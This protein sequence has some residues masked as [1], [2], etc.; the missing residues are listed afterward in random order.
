MVSNPSAQFEE[1]GCLTFSRIDGREMVWHIIDACDTHLPGHLAP[2]RV[3]Q[4]TSV[5]YD[6]PDEVDRAL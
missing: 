4:A 3:V 1:C 2:Y 6:F 5:T